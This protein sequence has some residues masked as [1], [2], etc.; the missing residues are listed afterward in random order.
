MISQ[1][2]G[3]LAVAE[4]TLDIYS[5]GV[6]S[7]KF[8]P[9]VEPKP[10]WRTVM[11]K[12]SDFGC[13][14]YRKVVRGDERF[15]PYFRSATPEPELGSTN[16]GS[17]P[18]KRR[19]GGVESLR[20]IPWVFA[21]TQTRLHLTTWLGVGG[22]LDIVRETDGQTLGDMYKNWPFFYTNIGE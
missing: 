7:E 17:R 1:N 4:R 19:P 9:V 15:V 16:I 13:E 18:Q 14:G 12:L 2:F 8:Q 10:E 20:A 22:A 11:K 3:H 6:L 21:W 5:A